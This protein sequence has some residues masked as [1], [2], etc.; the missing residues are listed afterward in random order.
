V[1][2]YLALRARVIAGCA[3]AASTL[4]DGSLASHMR[5]RPFGR[6]QPDKGELQLRQ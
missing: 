4:D 6:W 2:A 5:Y 1:T 3:T